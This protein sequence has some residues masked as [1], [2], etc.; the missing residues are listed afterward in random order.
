[1][2]VPACLTAVPAPGWHSGAEPFTQEPEPSESEMG[3]GLVA[4][5]RE[6]QRH[7]A[8]RL[9]GPLYEHRWHWPLYTPS[10]R[11]ALAG[12]FGPQ[13]FLSGFSDGFRTGAE[14]GAQLGEEPTGTDPSA[15]KG[16][17][18]GFDA[19]R[20]AR[21]DTQR[22]NSGPR[23]LALGDITVDAVELV[24]WSSP[25]TN[26]LLVVHLTLAGDCAEA[27]ESLAHLGREDL[28][29]WYDALIGDSGKTSPASTRATMVTYALPRAEYAVDA[30]L[31]TAPAGWE[32]REQLLWYMATATSSKRF[33]VSDDD[34]L[35]TQDALR[36]SGSW[37]ALVL[38]DG[39]AFLASP[40]VES[41]GDA[42]F[43][44]GMALLL[45]RSL[46]ADAIAL[47]VI[48]KLLLDEFADELADLKDPLQGGADDLLQIEKR[49]S[50]FRNTF[51][52][53]Q[54]A[55]SGHANRLLTA[56]GAQHSSGALF[57]QLH[58]EM[59]D[60]SRQIEREELR[61][62]NEASDVTN[63]LLGLVA[64]ISLLVGA[65]L[66]VLQT[67]GVDKTLAQAGAGS[68]FVLSIVLMASRAGRHLM[69]PLAP[70]HQSK[71]LR[72]AALVASLAVIAA[73]GQFVLHSP[74][75][76]SAGLGSFLSSAPAPGQS[77]DEQTAQ[78]Y[79]IVILDNPSGKL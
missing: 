51:W 2:L 33:A 69:K 49:F 63:A 17:A 70:A 28:R 13:A 66:A 5:T 43:K 29:A 62:A 73:V 10:N 54:I 46:Y 50:R 14:R 78:P 32:A 39:A 8:K 6:R 68:L 72:L 15:W 58:Q 71:L 48:Q 16:F 19:G 22:S 57:T 47:G 23:P 31:A 59:A 55:P 65:P 26:G 79:D 3:T 20:R 1:M 74:P 7:F 61:K 40:A 67:F 35:V 25:G 24:R 18:A 56:H 42:A 77:D 9:H 38:R 60:Y 11:S 44:R 37:S 76:A 45:T 36:L 64:F 30:A 4:S 53:H 41:S 52:W 21:N 12:E 27:F 75:R 34:H